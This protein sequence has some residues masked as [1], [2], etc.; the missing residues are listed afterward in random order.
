MLL[1]IGLDEISESEG[2]DR[3]TLALPKCQTD[4]LKAVSEV[5][6]NVIVVM[7]AGSSVE[8]PWLDQC[9]GLV[10]GYLCGQAGAS[11]VLRVILG[12]VNPS[13]K[14]SESY[15]LKYEDCSSAPYFP[16][17]E[18]SVEYREGLFVGY[19]YY[20]TA[21]MPVLFPFGF[22]LSYTT[23]SYSDLKVTDKKAVFTLTNTGKVDGAEVAQL[24]VHA[25]NPSVYRPYKELK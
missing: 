19:R 13:G 4:V 24:Y 9:K 7:S 14:L 1:Y 2:L 8:M 22:G 23:F 21:K 16:A 5:N 6:P 25:K 10:H 15:P 18:R 17:K 12:E 20:C 11:A 3:S